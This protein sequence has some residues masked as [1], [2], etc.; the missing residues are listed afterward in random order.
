MTGIE[1]PGNVVHVCPHGW[2]GLVLIGIGEAG[3]PPFCTGNANQ[4]E[5]VRMVGFARVA[6]PP[7]GAQMH[8]SDGSSEPIQR[9]EQRSDG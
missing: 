7:T 3:N 6:E 8:P 2:C 9:Q 5:P 4:H 1:Y